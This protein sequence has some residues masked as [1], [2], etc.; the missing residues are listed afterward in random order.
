MFY[1]EAGGTRS[2]HY[3]SSHTEDFNL[4]HCRKPISSGRNSD[5]SALK[6]EAAGFTETLVSVKLHSVTSSN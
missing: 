4:R 6:M 5:F 2:L 1:C 3:T